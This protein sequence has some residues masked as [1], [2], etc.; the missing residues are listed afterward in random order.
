MPTGWRPSGR[1]PS[2]SAA[3]RGS[4]S[5]AACASSSARRS[6]R[7]WA[8]GR[9]P[10]WDWRSRRRWPRWR[11]CRRPRSASRRRRAAARARA[12]D[13]DV[14]RTGAGRRGLRPRRPAPVGE[15]PDPDA[16]PRA[17]ARRRREAERARRHAR[18]LGQRR[19]DRQSQ[20]GPRPEAHVRRDRLADDDAHAA[21]LP[22]PR[23]AALGEGRRPLGLQPVGM[24]ALGARR[25]L[26]NHPPMLVAGTKPP[27][28]RAAS[29]AGWS[30]P[31]CSRAGAVTTTS[32]MRAP[33]RSC[34]RTP[35]PRARVAPPS[36][37]RAPAAARAPGDVV[38]AEQ[39]QP[40]AR[41]SMPRRPRERTRH[42][43]SA[44]PSGGVRQPRARRSRARGSSPASG[45][46]SSTTTSR[47]AFACARSAEPGH[48]GRRTQLRLRVTE[49][50][51]D[52]QQH[53]VGEVDDRLAVSAQVAQRSACTSSLQPQRTPI[54]PQRARPSG[55]RPRAATVS[56]MGA[57]SAAR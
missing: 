11:A 56:I 57:S 14:R 47:H 10:S 28:R 6:R 45:A 26:N 43:P 8:S 52:E 34:A 44:S 3:G 53:V 12:S 27:K 16:R 37:P 13:L 20:L 18:H 38:G 5:P 22:E 49:R 15:R 23:P 21:G 17:A 40:G 51:L 24:H 50:G 19:R 41:G 33:R 42:R 36:C 9:G 55:A 54:A 4:G 29:P 25:R 1:R 7:T 2:P 32:V 35:S 39:P 30:V 31:K 48:G 46:M